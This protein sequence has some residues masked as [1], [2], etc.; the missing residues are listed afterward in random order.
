MSEKNIKEK[1]DFFVRE[2]RYL[3]EARKK[4]KTIGEAIE[5][6]MNCSF[7]LG[8]SDIGIFFGVSSIEEAEKAIEEYRDESWGYYNSNVETVSTIDDLNSGGIS[9]S[10]EDNGQRKN[11]IRYSTVSCTNTFTIREEKDSNGEIYYNGIYVVSSSNLIQLSTAM[12][13]FKKAGWDC[14]CISACI[15]REKSCE[16]V[17]I[18]NNIVYVCDRKLSEEEI[19]KLENC[20]YFPLEYLPDLIERRMEALDIP[21]PK[22]RREDRVTEMNGVAPSIVDIPEEEVGTILEVDPYYS[23][24]RYI[25]RIEN[26]RKK[27]SWI[28]YETGFPSE[29]VLRKMDEMA[30]IEQEKREKE[31]IA[32]MLERRSVPEVVFDVE[33]D[34]YGDEDNKFNEVRSSY[35][36]ANPSKI[37]ALLIKYPEIAEQVLEVIDEQI[38]R[39]TNYEI[40]T[41]YDYNGVVDSYYIQ[42][43]NEIVECL[44]TVREYVTQ[45]QY[46]Q[47]T[48]EDVLWITADEQ[49]SVTEKIKKGIIGRHESLE[50][51]LITMDDI[52][53][54][55][56]K[57]RN[58]QEI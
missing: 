38:A 47:E 17:K 6:V 30:I 1:S 39:T 37:K 43:R 33:F 26:E 44:G 22:M 13:S 28:E 2:G 5:D 46:K 29:E 52:K 12:K 7:S 14:R 31:M 32:D 48:P 51:G 24:N 10:Q 20:S 55:I 42:R 16:G 45:E 27:Y 36:E 49:L 58:S 41:I 25:K 56:D 11:S 15:G 54:A 34:E 40:P 35:I 18:S 8:E 53:G 19:E 50:E 57:N 4:F 23:P 9:V 21:V 3:H